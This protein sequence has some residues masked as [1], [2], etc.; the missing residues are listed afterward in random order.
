MKIE[1]TENTLVFGQ[2]HIS[3]KLQR[4]ERRNLRIVV[5]P[6]LSVNVFAP[7]SLTECAT[8]MAVQK[9]G[10]WV[11]KTLDR[12]ADFHPLPSPKQYVS[13]ETFVYLGRQYRLRVEEGRATPAKLRGRFL[14]IRVPD[15]NETRRV[16]RAVEK[17]YEERANEILL[18]RLKVLHGIGAR[19]GIPACTMSIRRM[20]T[21]WGSCTA[22]GF[23]TLN[24]DLVQAPIHCAEYVIMHELCHLVHHNHSRAFYRLL[25]RCMPDWQKRKRI[26]D[27]IALPHRRDI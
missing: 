12:M 17:W 1:T 3:Y 11:A 21:R 20:R 16:R 22:R 19:N 8:V 10:P 14:C 5:S 15:K 26:L 25:T 4:S 7:K 2:R 18:G 27:Q 24:M 9:K 13:G 6:D 23:V